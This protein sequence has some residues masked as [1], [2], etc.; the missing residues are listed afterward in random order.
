MCD[1]FDGTLLCTVSLDKSLKV[2]DVIN[3]DMINMLKLDF[4]PSQCCFIHS[5]RDPIKAACVS[6]KDSKVLRIYDAHGTN[7]AIHTIEKLH[8]HPVNLI[9]YN[10]VFEIAVSTDKMG[11]LEYWSGARNDYEFPKNV[12]FESKMETDLYEF[13]KAKTI[14]LNIE[15]NKTGRVMATISKDRKIRI[16]NMLTG[17]IT[18]TIDESLEVYSTIQ[19][20]LKSSGQIKSLAFI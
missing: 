2:F 7:R 14:V 6:E 8:Y 15:F 9:K 5:D 18:K 1:N 11:M 20:V 4:T 3:F 13:A 17:K 16:F 10:H 12:A 19:Q